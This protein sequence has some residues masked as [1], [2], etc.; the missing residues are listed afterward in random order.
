MLIGKDDI[1]NDVITMAHVFQRLF[2]FALVSALRRLVEIWQLSWWGATG[3]LE[4][5]F[6]FWRLSCKLSF[7]FPPCR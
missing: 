2:T 5:E 7:L 4:V 3:E 1:S 6:K